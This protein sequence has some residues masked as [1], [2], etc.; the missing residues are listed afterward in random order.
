MENLYYR[1]KNVSMEQFATLDDRLSAED[2]IDF[3]TTLPFR[4]IEDGNVLVSR[5]EVIIYQDRKIKM[6]SVFDCFFEIKEECL[7]S[8]KKDGHIV[9]PR[10][11]LIQ[12]ASLN[13][14]TLRGVII[15]KTR[16][17]AFSSIILPPLLVADI[18][19]DDLVVECGA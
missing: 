13:Y 9:F 7:D 11:F 2:R 5:S 10:S 15:E 8:L 19:E 18:I 17:T 16:G 3:E 14:G 12:L 6:K 1:L 4:Y